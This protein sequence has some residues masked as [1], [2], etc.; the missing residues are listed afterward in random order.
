MSFQKDTQ[1]S[2]SN[3]VAWKFDQ[4]LCRQALTKMIIMDELPFMFVQREGFKN[5]C[6]VMQP[7]FRLISQIGRAHV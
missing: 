6:N 2:E 5:F 1:G 7:R 3:F 4:E